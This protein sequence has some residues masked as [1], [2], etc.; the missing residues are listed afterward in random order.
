MTELE[1]E[2]D[3]P[4][5]EVYA[6]FNNPDNLPLW[7]KGLQR[8]EII[9]GEPG[10]VGAKTRQI[11]LERGR[12]VEMIETITAHV[13]EKHMAGIIEGPGMNATL[14]INFVDR[15]EKTGLQ[16]RSN[17]KGISIMMSLMLPFM[18]GVIRKRQC[19]DLETF[20]R[21]VEAGELG[22]VG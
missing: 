19:G 5:R 15:G 2:I 18:R 10:K 22:E 3:K 8:T 17:F 4:L 11:Y 12:I 13:P 9:S 20:K 14:E 7:L 1:I 21:M 16:F 6:A